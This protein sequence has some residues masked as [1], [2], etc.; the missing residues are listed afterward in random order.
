MMSKDKIRLKEM[1]HKKLRKLCKKLGNEIAKHNGERLL[2][3][4]KLEN[5][6]LE[7]INLQGM[8]K[9][10]N[11]KIEEKDKRIEELEQHLDRYLM[12]IGKIKTPF[13]GEL[14]EDVGMGIDGQLRPYREMND[15]EHQAWVAREVARAMQENYDNVHEEQVEGN[16]IGHTKPAD[17]EE[18]H[19]PFDE[20]TN[21][22]GP[23]KPTGVVESDSQ[24]VDMVGALFGVPQADGYIPKTEQIVT[25][26]S[27]EQ[28][29]KKMDEAVEWAKRNGH[30]QPE[31]N[32]E[33]NK[34]DT[35]KIKTADEISAENIDKHTEMVCND[36]A[37]DKSRLL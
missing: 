3:R 23:A 26:V 12:P 4:K 17:V 33:P 28:I 8:L 30:H 10:K 20:P 22:V 32:P 21:G 13:I 9:T 11:K 14:P 27:Q 19:V 29:N 5:E 2:W 1:S 25:P 16:C 6:T 15:T 18:G 7:A 24:R 35:V 34:M 31:G 37:Q 36:I